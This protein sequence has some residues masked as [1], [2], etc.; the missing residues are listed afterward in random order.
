MKIPRHVCGQSISLFLL[1]SFTWKMADFVVSSHLQPK[2]D[3][4]WRITRPV[5]AERH[6]RVI[7]VGAGASGLLLAYKLQRHFSNFSL[8][9]YEKNPE[10]S[11]T[12][13]ENRYPGCAC[14]VPAHN[15]TW[16][17]EP[18]LDWSAVYASSKQIYEYFNDFATKYGLHDYVKTKHQVSGAYWNEE[19]GGYDVRIQDLKAGTKI[20]DHCDI[21]VNAGGILNNWRWP[22]IPGLDKYKGT[23]LHTANWDGNVHLEGRHVGLMGNG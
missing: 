9:V 2:N 20:S 17:F 19:K 12:W 11:G 13:F 3:A 5:H 15:Y 22:A 16:S 10:V 21:L 8:T 1:E 23:L 7:C 6:V 14:D 18:K 4:Q